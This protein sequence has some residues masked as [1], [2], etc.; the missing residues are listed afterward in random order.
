MIGRFNFAV[1]L[2]GGESVGREEPLDALGLARRHDRGGDLE[3]V[4]G[5]FA[6]L[7]L[8]HQPGPAWR[9]NLLAALGP[10][11]KAEAKSVRRVVTLILASPEA[12]LV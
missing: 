5:F 10:N 6:D 2:V 12:Q 4:V 11:A 8:G 9:D 1:A 3:A 7:V